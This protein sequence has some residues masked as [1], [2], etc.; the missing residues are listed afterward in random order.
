MTANKKHAQTGFSL[1]ELMVAM[2]V[3]LIM[4]GVA[5]TLF[6]RSL[7]VRLRESRTTDAL[8][9]AYAALNVM[10]REIS[11]GGFGLVN[12]A[13]GLATNGIVLADSSDHQIHVR[14]NFTNI[15]PYTDPNAPGQTNDP[16]EDVTYYFES[17]T[18]SIVRYDPHSTPTTSV[19]VNK[20]S[21]VTFNYYDYVTSGSS[22][23]GPNAAPTAATG[24]IVLTVT[25]DLEPVYGQPNPEAITFSSEVNMRNSNYMLQQY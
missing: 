5:S 24:R 21:N 18:K 6:S 2:T 1:L 13:T 11:N 10:S 12:P 16:G 7:G 19:V 9:S 17:A 22:G 25:V 15:T 23:T 8:T 14:S 3:M 4:M 20:I